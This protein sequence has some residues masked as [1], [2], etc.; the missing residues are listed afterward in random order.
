MAQTVESLK[1]NLERIRADLAFFT[2]RWGELGVPCWLELRAFAP[3]R[4]PQ[5]SKFRPD[6]AGLD[7]AAEWAV[8]MNTLRLNVYAVRNPIRDGVEG[9]AS[10]DDILAAFYLWADADD[11]A[12]AGN[13]HRFDG[14]KWTAALL[15]GTVPSKRVHVY[16]ELTEPAFN[17]EAWR[18]MQ[19]RIAAHFRSDR[20]VVNPSRIMRVSG[21]VS[22]PAP[23]KVQ[24]GY[25]SELTSLRTE[26]PDDD[27]REPLEFERALR[28]WPETVAA[29]STPAAS[30][31]I[32]TGPQPMDRER[33]RIQAL[34]GE[35][36]HNAVIKLVASYVAKGLADGEIH[37][38]TDPLTLPGYT[39]EQTRRE[40][41]TAIDG[42]RRKGF[43]PEVYAT[44]EAIEFDAPPA[45]EEEA[46]SRLEWFDDIRPSLDAGY[47]VKG[48]LDAGAMSV[49]YGASN[50]GKT[51]FAL[52]LAYHV[53]TGQTWR[54]RRVK[55]GGV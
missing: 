36:W 43:A 26:Y 14:P 49:L 24:R 16:W 10:D 3:D 41:Q 29:P 18:D 8:T 52:D 32:D 45:P 31:F 15:T 34:S 13:V 53:A 55:G 50:S 27:E 47:I 51:F 42:A 30:S 40:V 23:H 19:T 21:T 6:A 2:A 12:A 38:L 17:M 33:A 5:I 46:K 22:W 25:V 39:V 4:Q 1:P 11:E 7:L 54:D 44:P 35:E 20:K 48:M 37:A 28:V 9:S